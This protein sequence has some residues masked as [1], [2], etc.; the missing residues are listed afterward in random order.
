MY[1]GIDR[2]AIK[3]NDGIAVHEA[4]I[5]AIIRKNR[6]FKQKPENI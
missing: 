6:A 2:E 3:H 1:I 5:C 4:K